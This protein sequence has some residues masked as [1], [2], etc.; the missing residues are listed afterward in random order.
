MIL[1]ISSKIH[2]RLLKTQEELMLFDPRDGA[3]AR[4]ITERELQR[5]MGRKLHTTNTNKFLDKVI[6]LLGTRKLSPQNKASIPDTIPSL[7]DLQN[8]PDCIGRKH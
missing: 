7:S 3:Q 6:W 5:H 8:I 2:P 1:I 4:I